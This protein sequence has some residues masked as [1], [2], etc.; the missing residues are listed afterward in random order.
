MI[1]AIVLAAGAS[2]RFGSQ[3]LVAQLRG[4]PIVR[5]AVES[6]LAADVDEVLVVVGR[7][8]EAVREA[9]SGLAVRI[10]VNERWASGLGA[11]LRAGVSALPPAADATLIVL[12]DQPGVD[13]GVI[14]ALI[15]TYEEG[16][17]LIV[18][19][20]YRGERGHPVI[21]GAG[22]FRELLDVEGDRGAKDVIARDPSRVTLVELDSPAP[23]DVDTE[24]ELKLVA[25]G[26][27]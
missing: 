21:F 18:A 15:S 5:W 27:F 26:P 10:V 6:V 14:G 22:I 25:G 16:S 12:G 24:A 13:A 1:A 8:G 11:S 17:S 3:K 7:E 20:S 19:P 2:R 23:V 9:L 4:K